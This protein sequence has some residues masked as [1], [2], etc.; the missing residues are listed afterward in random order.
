MAPSAFVRLCRVVLAAIGICP[1]TAVSECPETANLIT[2]GGKAWSRCQA[3]WR[4]QVAAAS[5]DD[6]T[7]LM[8]GLSL[9]AGGRVDRFPL[10]RRRE[11]VIV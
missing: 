3:E 10:Q 9:A 1:L 6:R 8:N 4:S 2:E 11:S 5:G 7:Y